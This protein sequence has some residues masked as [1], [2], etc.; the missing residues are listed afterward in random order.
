MPQ[1]MGL[2]VKLG[3]SQKKQ[4]GHPRFGLRRNFQ[5]ILEHTCGGVVWKQ[6]KSCITRLRTHKIR[7][8]LAV[9]MLS[10]KSIKPK[11]FT[12]PIQRMS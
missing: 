7:A 9:L 5:L 1:D 10:H 12:N 4:V 3:G 11:L 2:S 6:G 8:G